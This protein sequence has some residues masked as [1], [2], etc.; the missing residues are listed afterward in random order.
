M[1][2]ATNQFVIYFSFGL[3]KMFMSTPFLSLLL[4]SFLATL[5]LG[6]DR[7]HVSNGSTCCRLILLQPGIVE[8]VVFCV[9]VRSQFWLSP[10]PLSTVASPFKEKNRSNGGKGAQ[11]LT[12]SR[13][14]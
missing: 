9:A 10:V 2:A 8:I 13:I 1:L 4:S 5:Y 7:R 14:V 11:D 12:D 6:S 3:F